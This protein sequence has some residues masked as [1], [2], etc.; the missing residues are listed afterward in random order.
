MSRIS[1]LRSRRAGCRRA[2]DHERPGRSSV[3]ASAPSI[4]DDLTTRSEGRSV[5]RERSSRADRGQRRSCSCLRWLRVP[6]RDDAELSEC[7]RQSAGS[8]R[9]PLRPTR[10][11]RDEATRLRDQ[12]LSLPGLSTGRC[13]CPRGSARSSSL[14]SLAFGKLTG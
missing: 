14:P 3:R 11:G 12:A 10:V 6:T 13:R 9:Q 7:G 4:G 5:D 1:W 8:V 2:G